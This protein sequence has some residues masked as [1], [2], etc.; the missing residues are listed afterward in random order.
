MITLLLTGCGGSNKR[1]KAP[2]QRP[3]KTGV[4]SSWTDSYLKNKETVAQQKALR[5]KM[6]DELPTTKINDMTFDQLVIARKYYDE[7]GQHDRAIKCYERLLTLSKDSLQLNSLRLELA[8]RFFEEGNFEKA[9]KLYTG[10]L[11]FY[12]GSDKREYVEYKAILAHFYLTLSSDRDQTE[13]KNTLALTQDFLAHKDIY[14]TYS[15][16]VQNI[17]KQCYEKL[18]QSEMNICAFHVRHGNN[19]GAEQRLAY[20]NKHLRR[21]APELEHELLALET[22]VH[23]AVGL[24]LPDVQNALQQD[25]V[26]LADNDT[27]SSKKHMANRF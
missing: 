17:Q 10:F 24:P 22:N 21:H 20:I 9:G 27:T 15:Q 12:P 3:N 8:D 6:R 4:F 25:N 16:E 5:Q 11:E 13:T 26:V 7:L 19:K 18:T 23:T 14:T 2:R 1:K